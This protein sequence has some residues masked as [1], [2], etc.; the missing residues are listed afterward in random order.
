VATSHATGF[1]E[2]TIANTDVSKGDV[3]VFGTDGGGTS[4]GQAVAGLV[5]V[6]SN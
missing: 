3:I 2:L 5:I 1:L 6:P 4:T